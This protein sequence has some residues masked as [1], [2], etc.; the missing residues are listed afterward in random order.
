M[1]FYTKLFFHTPCYIH[2][3][4]FIPKQPKKDKVY[5]AKVQAKIFCGHQV[6]KST[7]MA[8]NCLEGMPEEDLLLHLITNNYNGT[9]VRGCV[10]CYWMFD[11]IWIL[12]FDQTKIKHFDNQYSRRVRCKYKEGYTKKKPT[13]SVKYS[14]AFMVLMSCTYKGTENPARIHGSKDSMMY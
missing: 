3:F 4:L 11:W 12:W 14:G 1:L 13:P 2:L 10:T 5:F 6:S 9:I 8:K 7:S